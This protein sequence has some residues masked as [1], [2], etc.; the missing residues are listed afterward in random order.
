[1][2]RLVDHSGEFLALLGIDIKLRLGVARLHL[3]VLLQIARAGQGCGVLGPGLEEQQAGRCERTLLPRLMK[4]LASTEGD[5]AIATFAARLGSDPRAGELLQAVQRAAEQLTRTHVEP[6]GTVRREAVV[7]SSLRFLADAAAL[8]RAFTVLATVTGKPAYRQ[9][10]E[11]IAAAMWTHF[12]DAKAGLLWVG[13][14]DPA[15][16]GVFARRE[17]SFWQN[18]LAARFLGELAAAPGVGAPQRVLY[19]T[20]ARALLTTLSTPSELAGQGRLLGD[21]VLAL[22]TVGLLPWS[23]PGAP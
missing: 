6:D 16:S 11:K 14:V 20:R 8:G 21:Y 23:K 18:T 9:L 5:A 13:T 10:A 19:R 22:D 17:H 1:M 15:A 12:F 4:V 3:Q 7:T 2:R